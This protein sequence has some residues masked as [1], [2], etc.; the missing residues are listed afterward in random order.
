M[1]CGGRRVDG[2]LRS[3][4]ITALHEVGQELLAGKEPNQNV[5]ELE[6]LVESV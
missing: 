4:T 1:D 5:H 2:F 3:N 6:Q